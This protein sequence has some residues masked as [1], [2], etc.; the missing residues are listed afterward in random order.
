MLTREC[1]SFTG[2]RARRVSHPSSIVVLMRPAKLLRRI[3]AGDHANVRFADLTRLVEACGFELARVSGSHR[4][5]AH[6][7]VPRCRASSTSR[8]W[9][10]WPSRTRFA[11]FTGSSSATICIRRA[12]TRERLPHQRLLQRGGWRLHR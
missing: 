7:K 6:P 12:K 10:A 4:I 8:K 1:K 5:F 3:T 2:R 9:P 11:R